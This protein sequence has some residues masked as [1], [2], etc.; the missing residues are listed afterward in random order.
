M[1]PAFGCFAALAS[2]VNWRRFDRDAF[3]DAEQA[4]S[5]IFLFIG[6]AWCPYSQR[7]LHGLQ[8]DAA[9]VTE[10]NDQYIPIL[11]DGERRPDV[12]LRYPAG[13]WPGILIL[14]PGG[15]VLWASTHVPGGQLARLLAKIRGYFQANRREVR[16][17]ARVARGERR[18]AARPVP[19]GESAPLSAAI[20]SD[21]AAA[22]VT[23]YDADNAGF[24][25]ETGYSGPKFPNF[26]TIELLLTLAESDGASPTIVEESLDALL[27][28][29]LWDADAG[30]LGRYAAERDWSHVHGEKLLF[31]QARLL[32]LLCQ[33]GRQLQSER[34]LAHARRVLDWC[35]ETLGPDAPRFRTSLRPAHEEVPADWPVPVADETVFTLPHAAIASALLAAA[36]ALDDEGA[37]AQATAILDVL[38]E[39]GREDTGRI[40]HH[41]AD[42]VAGTLLDHAALAEAFLDAFELTGQREFLERG[43]LVFE[44]ASKR[45]KQHG[46]AFFDV[47]DERDAAGR[48]QFRERQAG[49]NAAVALVALRLHALTRTDWYRE[50][51][52]EALAEFA[53]GASKQG[54]LGSRYATAVHRY[55]EPGPVAIVVGSADTAAARSLHAAVRQLPIR[56]LVV[57]MLDP[58]KDL[59]TLTRF[60]V[61]QSRDARAYL[62]RDGDVQGPWTR[63]EE[64]ADVVELAEAS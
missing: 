13:G 34:L 51:A 56:E 49:P 31:D 41:L 12:P 24:A 45:F 58:L 53:R 64:M 40:C 38:W 21:I 1:D 29:G 55:R 17:N 18:T 36:S 28:R 9:S 10:L 20:V 8:A 25:L 61:P 52:T 47:T 2:P 11:V 54:L 23:A 30:G 15:E 37:L 33:A 32:W 42:T 50:T 35:R 39:E 62:W 19:Q 26:D 57:Q 43:E 27:S 22:A 16:T 14:E 44:A 6:A 59:E 7:F 63:P 60:G 46:G 4:G 5:L 48:C 3:T